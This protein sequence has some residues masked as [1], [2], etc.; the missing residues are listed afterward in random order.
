MPRYKCKNKECISCDKIITRD[1]VIKFVNGTL[2]HIASICDECL[3][4]MEVLNEEG[5]T[6][7]MHGGP[8]ICKN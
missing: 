7:F 2:F 4:K 6:T 3:G 8:N 5:F 1:T